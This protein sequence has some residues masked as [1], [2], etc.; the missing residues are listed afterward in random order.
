MTQKYL[1]PISALVALF[2][3]IVTYM[4]E[5]KSNMATMKA[6]Y[7]FFMVF[8]V[9]SVLGLYICKCDKESYGFAYSSNPMMS[10][11]HVKCTNRCMCQNCPFNCVGCGG[12]GSYSKMS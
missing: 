8:V 11:H 12:K 5:R 1:F 10:P 3:A 4:M 6:F 7:Q 9:M 2:F